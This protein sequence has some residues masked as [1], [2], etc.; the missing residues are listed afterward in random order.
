[1]SI[2]GHHMPLSTLGNSRT[3]PRKGTAMTLLT[4]SR[5]RAATAVVAAALAVGVLAAPAIAQADGVPFGPDVSRWQHPNGAKIDW[6]QVAAAGSTFAI[7]KATESSSYTNPYFATDVADAANL[8]SKGVDEPTIDNWMGHQTAEQ[9]ERYRHLFPAG[10]KRSIEL[11][12]CSP[13]GSSG[14]SSC[15]TRPARARDS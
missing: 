5:S 7:V 13:P 6:A 1:M 11:L 2:F 12:D 9:R 10:L 4:R 15:S 14:R 8:A 3:P